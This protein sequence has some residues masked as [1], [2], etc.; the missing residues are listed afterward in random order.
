MAAE[1]HLA[2]DALALHLLLQHLEGLVDIVVTDENLHAAFLFDRAVDGPGGADRW[3]SRPGH[4]RTDMHNAGADGTRGT[5]QRRY[6]EIVPADG[7]MAANRKKRRLRYV[8]VFWA[9]LRT[10]QC[11]PA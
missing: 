8:A 4:W 5:N 6:F 10:S 11:L 9:A 7:T 1:L 3:P 2:E